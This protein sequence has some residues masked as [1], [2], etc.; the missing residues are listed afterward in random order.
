[1]R[2]WVKVSI[3]SAIVVLLGFSIVAGAGAYFFFRHL[4]T[5]DATESDTLREMDAIRERFGARQPLIEVVDP[6]SADIRINR[7]ADSE[8]RQVNTIHV[9]TWSADDGTRLQTEM[10][11]WFMRFSSV[12]ILSKLGVAPERFRLTVDDLRRYG[13]GIVVDYRRPGD[14]HVLIWV[15]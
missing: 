7:T 12:N 15:D 13:P 5:G 6:R 3:G 1:M 9:L 4:S 2:T 11:L 8:G 10:P 14:A